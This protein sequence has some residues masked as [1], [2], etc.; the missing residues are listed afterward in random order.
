[1]ILRISL[2]SYEFMCRM[3]SLYDI[4]EEDIDGVI[5]QSQ[6]STVA[7]SSLQMQLPIL[8]LLKVR[9]YH[10]HAIKLCKL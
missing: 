7:Q 6:L 2:T 5:D 3:L 4:S 10:V 9:V 1:M 8:E